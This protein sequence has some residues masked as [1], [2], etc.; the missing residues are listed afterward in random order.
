M[1]L[2]TSDNEKLKQHIQQT[3]RT[4]AQLKKEN[5]DLNQKVNKII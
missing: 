4:I 3:D 5:E 1:R 2:L